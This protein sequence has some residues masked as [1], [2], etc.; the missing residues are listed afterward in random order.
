VRVLIGSAAQAQISTM[1]ESDQ[2]RIAAIL[3]KLE[4]EFPDMRGP[5]LFQVRR[6][7]NLWKLRVTPNLL[8]LVQI[9]GD[10]AIVVAVARQDQ[11]HLA[12]SSR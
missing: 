7:G 4:Y 9:S 10:L 8:A 5:E 12:P 1:P 6:T 2:R 11:L 3:Q